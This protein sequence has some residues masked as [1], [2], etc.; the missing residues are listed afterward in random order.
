MQSSIIGK[1]NKAKV[2]ANE[3]ERVSFQN[4]TVS[5]QG[6]NDTH[7]VSLKDDAWSCTCSFFGNWGFCCHTMAMEKLLEKMLKPEDKV[8]F[9]KAENA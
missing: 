4:M 2:Y 3:P 9:N 5:F 8:N 7:T 6:E 1:I